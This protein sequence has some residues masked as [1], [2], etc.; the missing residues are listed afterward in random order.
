MRWIGILEPKNQG[1]DH[2]PGFSNGR[3]SFFCVKYLKLGRLPV[4]PK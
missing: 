3:K 1:Y 4:V 2:I